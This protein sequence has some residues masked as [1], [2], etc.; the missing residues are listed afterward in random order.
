[1]DL[2]VGSNWI[3]YFNIVIIEENLSEMKIS[4]DCGRVYHHS[5]LSTVE[6]YQLD[7]LFQSEDYHYK[8]MYPS[9]CYYHSSLLV[10]SYIQEMKA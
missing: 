9:V 2:P 1:M 5:S 3:H 7:V 10:I 8:N 4:R 6:E